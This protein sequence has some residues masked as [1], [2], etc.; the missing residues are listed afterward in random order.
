MEDQQQKQDPYNLQRFLDAQTRVYADVCAELR[1]GQKQ[2]HWMWYIFPQLKGL[3]DS[4]NSLFYGIS[5][6]EEAEA[7][8]R[9]PVLGP[10]L[11]ECTN[12]VNAVEGWTINQIFS[13]PDP[14]KFRSCM[15]LL[16]E[17]ASDN[18][19]FLLALSKYFAGQPDQATLAR[20]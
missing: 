12:I 10:R 13:F 18:Q 1:H 8:L 2:T 15:T 5:G 17:M 16:S 19:E 9:H 11:R 7:Y 3:G 4:S 6:R 20:L 14:L